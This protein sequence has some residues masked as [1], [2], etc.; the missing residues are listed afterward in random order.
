[1][2]LS[3]NT[4]E[5]NQKSMYIWRA[6]LSLNNDDIDFF[7][8]NSVNRLYIRMF[9]VVWDEQPIPQSVL[10]FSGNIPENIEI[11]PVVFIKNEVVKNLQPFD[12]QEFTKNVY[13][14]LSSVYS[15]S[16]SNHQI[17]E[18]QIDCDW[19]ATSK[20]K[21][22]EF[23]QLLKQTIGDDI[24]ISVTVRLHQ[25]KYQQSTGIPPV[26][27]GVLMYYNMGDVTNPDENN[28]IIDNKIGQQYINKNSSYPIE[29][30]LALPLYSWGLWY[31]WQSKVNVIY[32]ININTIDNINYLEKI[33]KNKYR[34]TCD[35]VVDNKF[36]R[37]N[38][39][40]RLE[41]VT[42]DDLQKAENICQN[43]L[44]SNYELIFYSY[45]KKLTN[46][47]SKDSLNLV[48]E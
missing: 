3:C 5:N 13:S 41:F 17:K 29:L 43:V 31:N 9:D 24:K 25:I 44:K 28:S 36:L 21:Y 45:N 33:S 35:T 1:M 46:L 37:Q 20:E 10:H 11:I 2:F 12:L 26:D 39:I 32:S 16:F 23:L 48:F 27:K 34:V 14:K 15:L 8:E 7:A 30:S 40:I 18:I 22:F 42:V 19:T 38:D 6:K 47:L 4:G